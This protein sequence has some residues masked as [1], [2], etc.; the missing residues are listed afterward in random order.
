MAR[1]GVQ[2][3]S[4]V[5]YVYEDHGIV[6]V[7]R[8]D[9]LPLVGPSRSLGSIRVGIGRKSLAG[10]PPA[11]AVRLVC[12]AILTEMSEPSGMRLAEGPGTPGRGHGVEHVAGQLR[13]DLLV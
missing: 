9:Y 11:G 4:F 10:L 1:S 3:L 6:T 13:L 7:T 12:D 2:G 8:R 5:L